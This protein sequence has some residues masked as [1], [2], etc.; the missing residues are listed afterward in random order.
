MTENQLFNLDKIKEMTSSLDGLQAKVYQLNENTENVKNYTESLINYSTDETFLSQV[1]EIA[2]IMLTVK[3]KLEK[4]SKDNISTFLFLQENLIKKYKEKNQAK[5]KKLNITQA[6]LREIGLYLIE[7]KKINKT[8]NK[9]SYIPSIEVSQWSEILD[10]LKENSLFLKIIKKVK[11]FYTN[12]IQDKLKL[13]LSKLPQNVDE[14]I[15]KAYEK[16]FLED[17]YISFSDF[18]QNF[19]STLTQKE[20]KSK[21]EYISK[22]KEQEELERLKKK[23]EEQR[24]AYDDYLKLSDKAFERKIR[25]KSREK[26]GTIKTVSK[27]KK[28]LELSEE[29]SEKIE[30]FKSKLDNSFEEKYLIQQD[31]D[32]DPLDLIRERKEKKQKEYKKYKDHFDNS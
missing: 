4:I 3:N 24:E 30:K 15:I 14:T 5:I 18:L 12:I 11:V 2:N 21:R 22:L 10:S 20:L 19:E 6:Q 13:E 23:Q 7:M 25:K 1:K 9:I 31:D 26:L 28:N 27:K 29:I 8:I 32:K 16:A 17:P